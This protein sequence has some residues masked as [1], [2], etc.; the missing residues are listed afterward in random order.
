MV[1]FS[2]VMTPLALMEGSTPRA[3]FEIVALAAGR[4]GT[5][6]LAAQ[7]VIMTTDQSEQLSIIT[8]IDITNRT[9]VLNTVPFG[10]GTHESYRLS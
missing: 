1:D 8:S 10:I 5:L 6:P 9:S 4:L 3:A 2:P 7:S